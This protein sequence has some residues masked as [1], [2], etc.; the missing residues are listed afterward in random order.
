MR[1]QGV[2]VNELRDQVLAD[3]ALACNEDLGVADGRARGQRVDLLHG[4]TGA[5]NQGAGN[6]GIST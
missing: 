3:A 5:D 6:C 2:R 1:A 4:G